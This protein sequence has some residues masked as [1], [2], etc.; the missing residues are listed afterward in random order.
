MQGVMKNGKLKLKI[1]GSQYNFLKSSRKA[2]E[3]LD[4]AIYWVHD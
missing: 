1:M 3:D 2:L 4:I